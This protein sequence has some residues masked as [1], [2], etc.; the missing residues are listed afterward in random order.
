MQAAFEPLSRRKEDL[1]NAPTA[2]LP[3]GSQQLVRTRLVPW[4]LQGDLT[5]L[6]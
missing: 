4:W 2:T 6:Q 3:T 1:P 5:A